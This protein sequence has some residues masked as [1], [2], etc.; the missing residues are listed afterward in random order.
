M[1]SFTEYQKVSRLLIFTRPL[2]QSFADTRH[3]LTYPVHY[4][5]ISADLIILPCV[6][7]SI[8]ILNSTYFLNFTL[9]IQNFNKST[10]IGDIA[11][12]T[13]DQTSQTQTSSSEEDDMPTATDVGSSF[14]TS[15]FFYY[16]IILTL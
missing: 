1:E 15:L 5:N 14:F 4:I 3:D 16:N 11:E 7:L 9:N 10:F 8:L 2:S 12:E 13:E 6:L